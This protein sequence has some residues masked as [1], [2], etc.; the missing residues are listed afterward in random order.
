MAV[1]GT[2]GNCSA[3]LSAT[4]SVTEAPPMGFSTATISSSD[5][6]Q[7]VFS[8]GTSGA[9]KIDQHFEYGTSGSPVSLAANAAIT[10]IL[11][12]LGSS[13][14]LDKLK[15]EIGFG[16]VTG[17]WIRI[18]NPNS[19]NYLEITPGVTNGFALLT[20]ATGVLRVKSFFMWTDDVSGLA[21]VPSTTEQLT[22]TAKNG[23]VTFLL[24]I[25]GTTG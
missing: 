11:S 23:T 3:A 19:A 9:G 7:I 4:F 2:M 1:Y 10:L 22:I 13:T 6:S 25:I 8:A 18:T 5:T 21:V 15:R 14:Y 24:G 16:H 17:F 12:D 20:G